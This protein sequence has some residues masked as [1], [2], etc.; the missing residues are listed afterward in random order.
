MMETSLLYP[1]LSYRVLG[2]CFAVY[3]C[4]GSH[5]REAVYHKALEVELTRQEIGFESKKPI[6]L[7]YH[8]ICIG[9][10]ELDLIIERSIILELK[11]VEVFHPQHLAQLIQYLEITGLKLGMLINFGN[12]GGLSYRRVPHDK[13]KGV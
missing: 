6:D 2:C 7:S 1:E 3:N 8:G 5:Y 13:G 12:I 9:Q 4:L 10:Y 11:A